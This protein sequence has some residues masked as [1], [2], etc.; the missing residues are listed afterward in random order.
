MKLIDHTIED[1]INQVD[2]S[3]PAPGGG[4]VSALSATMGVALLRMVG[5]ITIGRKAFNKYSEDQQQAFIDAWNKL[6]DIKQDL[7]PLIDEDTDAFNQIMTAFKLPKTTEDEIK[8]R[9]QAIQGATIYAID[10]PLRVA[11]LCMKALRT[12]EPIKAYGNR[13]AI[14][15]VEVAELQLQAACHG[16]LKNV[17]INITSLSNQKL[18][19]AYQ[20]QV[21]AILNQI[22]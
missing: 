10:V 7:I 12:I 6:D 11:N 15:D 21:D 9:Q 13:N 22:Q 2:S 5:H 18:V 4:S 3:S 14:S 19:E 8:Y 20:M 1:F 17:S 16:A